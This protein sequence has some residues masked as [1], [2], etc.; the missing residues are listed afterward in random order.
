MKRCPI[1]KRFGVEYDPQTGKEKCLWTDCLWIN[2]ENID[3][4]RYNYGVNF[5]D[6]RDT[7]S[8]KREMAV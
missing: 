7:I 2:E 6:F 3:L 4:D 1:C 5:A 8:I